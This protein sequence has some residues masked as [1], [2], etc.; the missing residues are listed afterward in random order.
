MRPHLSERKYR[1]VK[2]NGIYSCRHCALT[3][4]T[5]ARFLYFFFSRV[6]IAAMLRARV[7]RRVAV[8]SARLSV[9]F[10]LYFYRSNWARSQHSLFF[11]LFFRG[12]EKKVR[13]ISICFILAD[14]VYTVTYVGINLQLKPFF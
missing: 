11:L 3:H 4:V 2:I 8:N 5:G 9:I 13:T 12:T 1:R 7:Q 10:I 6:S 14:T